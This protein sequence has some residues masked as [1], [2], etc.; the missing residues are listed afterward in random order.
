MYQAWLDFLANGYYFL[1][2]CHTYSWRFCF[3]PWYQ[4]K[5]IMTKVSFWQDVEVFELSSFYAKV[6]LIMR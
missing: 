5:L 2:S 1:S 4:R 6:K 3:S